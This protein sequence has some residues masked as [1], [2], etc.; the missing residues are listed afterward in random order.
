MFG[1]SPWKMAVGATAIVLLAAGC[2]SFGSDDD[3]DYT[4]SAIIGIVEPSTLVPTDTTETNGSQVLTSLFYPLVDFD[5]HNQPVN[6]AAESIT[7]SDNKVWT[8]KLKDGSFSNGEKVTSDSYIQA[9]N[10]GAYGPN[11][12][13]GSYFYERIQGYAALQ[14]GTSAGKTVAPK[15]TQMSGLKKI[16]DSTFTI[17]LSSAFAGWRYVLAYNVF[18]PLPDAAFSS[19]GVLKKGFNEAPI[20]NGPFKMKG[21]W[22]HDDQIQ[23]VRRDDFKGPK[24]NVAGVIWKIYQ[25]QNSEYADL[26]AGN[27]DVQTTIPVESLSSAA[28]DLG[29]HY[30]K[31][32]NSV[33]QFVGFPTFQ[34]EFSNPNVRKAISMAINRKEMTDQIFLGSQ[35]PAYSFVSPAVN[36]YRPNTCGA[37]CQYNPAAAK[38]LYHDNGGPSSLTISYNADGPNKAW[39]DTMCVQISDSLGVPCTGVPIPK[40][41]DLLAKAEDKQPTGMFRLGWVMDYPLME[42]YLGPIYSTEGSSNYWGYHNSAF[43][44]LVQQGNDA[45]TSAEAIKKWQSAEDILA[46]DMPVIPLRF[47]QNVYGYSE[48]TSDVSVNLE[49]EVDLYKIKIDTTK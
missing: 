31:S 3:A 13:S 37:A 1:K 27:V 26:V 9:W 11:A 35:T 39:I 47:G 5:D 7:S 23:V 6:E 46:Q 45:K 22:Q 34:K 38:T 49:Q 32:P 8:V 25:D 16:D 29:T 30:A 2:S 44:D 40:F 42:D 33:F 20:G 17:T 18:D 15:A 14:N 24:P 36:G 12:Q 48:R 28:G 19:P 41:S 4:D 21:T 10:Y 43:D